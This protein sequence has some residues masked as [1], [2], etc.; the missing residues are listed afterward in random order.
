[1]T[2]TYAEHIGSENLLFLIQTSAPGVE[3]K[4]YG[5]SCSI[6]SNSKVDLSSQVYE[7]K[8]SNCTD[9]SKPAKTVRRVTGLDVKFTGSGMTDVASHRLLVQKWSQ[10]AIIPGKI[11]QDTGEAATG[12]EVEGGWIIDSIGLGGEHREDQAFDISI[13]TDG[14]FEFAFP[15]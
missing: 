9:P 7:G 1:M 14:S 6:N 8:R 15:A 12:W 4:V 10:G 11:M 2:D 3:P 13:S 5:A